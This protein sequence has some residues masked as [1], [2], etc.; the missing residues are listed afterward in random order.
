MW[1]EIL[2]ANLA[3]SFQDLIAKVQNLVTLEPVLGAIW[4]PE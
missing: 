1:L 2:V 3:T 4:S